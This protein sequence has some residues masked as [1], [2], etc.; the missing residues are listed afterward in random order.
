MFNK[1]ITASQMKLADAFTMQSEPISSIDLMERA[2]HAFVD[3]ILHSISIDQTKEIAIFCGSGNNGGD[4]FAVTRILQERGYNVNAYLVQFRTD[5]SQD[6][7]KNFNRL[8]NVEVI[9]GT[10]DFPSLEGTDIIIDAIFGY[11]FKG[12][13]RGWVADLIQ[14]INE[15]DKLVYAIDTPSGLES[16]GIGKGQV[17]KA[18]ET[19]CFQR[20]KLAFFLPENGE[21]IGDWKSVN[22]GL[23]EQYIQEIDSKLFM[24]NDHVKTLVQPR[25]RQSHKG[26]YGHV[27]IIAGAYGKIGA[28]V[29]ATK[30]ALRTG[31][32]LVTTLTPRCGY[33]I[34][35]ST[36][37]EAMC[38]TDENEKIIATPI[39]TSRFS[40]VGIGPGIGVEK[41][42]KKVL[43][44]ILKQHRPTVIDADALNLISSDEKLLK[45]LHP[46]CVLTP[47]IKEFDRIVG[48]SKTSLE[49]FEKQRKFVE[50]HECVVVLKDAYTSI[51]SPITGNQYFNTSG[52]SGMATG[53]SGDVLTGM[54]TG[55]LAQGY[56]PIDAALIG[57]YYHGVAGQAAAEI[58]GENGMIASDILDFIRL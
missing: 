10:K 41:E 46:N 20:P 55:L 3:A 43:K 16:D 44:N 37:P 56:S 25:Q 35:Q 53:G 51:I 40:V 27:L 47:H 54:I 57:V 45:L 18:K 48:Q 17:I 14:H 24:L 49:R 5:L 33:Q 32:G 58:R 9:D 23:N 15:L 30:G 1:I 39:D 4:G 26:T 13:T 19:Y 12:K 50:E 29:L 6:C 38:I 8:T 34:L 2:S 11:G 21:F 28:S 36:V 31:A 22:I 7:Q 42:T 52:C